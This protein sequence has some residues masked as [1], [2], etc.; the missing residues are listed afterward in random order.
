MSK[1]QGN[2]SALTA[3][4]FYLVYFSSFSGRYA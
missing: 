4:S 1:G 2:T 3:G